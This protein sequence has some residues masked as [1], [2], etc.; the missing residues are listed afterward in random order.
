MLIRRKLSISI[1]VPVEILLS[2]K[3]RNF[4]FLLCP[5]VLSKAFAPSSPRSFHL[6]SI[7]FKFLLF[8][9]TISAKKPAKWC[10]I[11]LF[12]RSINS[13]YCKFCTRWQRAASPISA[14]PI[15]FHSASILLRWGQCNR[16]VNIIS[17]PYPS[18]LFPFTLICL[19][20]WWYCGIIA[21]TMRAP[22]YP[23]TRSLRSSVSLPLSLTIKF[24]IVCLLCA[25][26]MFLFFEEVV[27]F[28]F[29]LNFYIET[30]YFSSPKHRKIKNI[31]DF[32]SEKANWVYYIFKI[33]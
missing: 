4:I 24:S 32:C 18:M 21:P 1:R 30:V 29:N 15:L 9:S 16:A 6:R 20:P 23:S 33:L 19:I 7:T 26:I 3:P 27:T 5:R 28:T 22:S 14:L 11:L 12:F 17:N 10:P 8:I 31:S 2:S 25:F 13:R